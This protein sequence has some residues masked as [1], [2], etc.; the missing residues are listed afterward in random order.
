MKQRLFPGHDESRFDLRL[1]PVKYDFWE[2]WSWA[3]ILN[4]FAF[5]AGNTVGIVRAYVDANFLVEVPE[6]VFPLDGW[7]LADFQDASTVRA[8]VGIFVL[9]TQMAIEAL[10]DLLPLLGIPVDAVAVVRPVAERNIHFV[11]E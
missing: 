3:T 9:D 10:P 11:P 7:E 2:L 4:R 5:S 8:T 1:I 6:I